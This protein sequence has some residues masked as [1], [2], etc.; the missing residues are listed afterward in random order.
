[1]SGGHDRAIIVHV[2][3]ES[4]DDPRIVV[5]INAADARNSGGPPALDCVGLIRENAD[6][7]PWVLDA[8]SPR[9][10]QV[11]D[12]LQPQPKDI[13]SRIS[14]HRFPIDGVHMRGVVPAR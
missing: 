6:L 2:G 3:D 12:L 9:W 13:P 1:M 4:A 5:G 8:P 11:G 7:H 14:R 10:Q